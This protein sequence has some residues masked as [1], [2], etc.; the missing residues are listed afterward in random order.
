VVREYFTYRSEDHHN[1]FTRNGWTW[2]WLLGRGVGGWELGGGSEKNLRPLHQWSDSGS[3]GNFVGHAE[4][5]FTYWLT[6]A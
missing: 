6:K 5:E 2:I 3:C 4:V 1:K